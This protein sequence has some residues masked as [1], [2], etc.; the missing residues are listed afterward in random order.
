MAGEEL[1]G[2]LCEGELGALFRF[3]S[4]AA[5]QDFGLVPRFMM[6]KNYIQNFS[7][8]LQCGK[9]GEYLW[10]G[11]FCVSRGVWR[12]WQGQKTETHVFQSDCCGSGAS[13]RIIRPVF[14]FLVNLLMITVSNNFRKKCSTMVQRTGA[15]WDEWVMRVVDWINRSTLA[16]TI[17]N[18]LI[19]EGQ[20][21]VMDDEENAYRSVSQLHCQQKAHGG[22]LQSLEGDKAN[23]LAFLYS[24]SPL[25]LAAVR[26]SVHLDFWQSMSSSDKWILFSK[27]HQ[28]VVLMLKPLRF[29]KGPMLKC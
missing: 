8:F 24:I 7:F 5:A 25:R 19:S 6:R 21:P 15:K 20:K 12:P 23:S 9:I 22:E 4:V 3:P 1:A 29:D 28:A 14:C 17:E 26:C 27:N 13:M 11:P 10:F 18:Q 16:L 2:S